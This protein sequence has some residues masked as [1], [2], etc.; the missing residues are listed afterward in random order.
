[1]S[2]TSTS[3]DLGVPREAD[4]LYHQTLNDP[5]DPGCVNACFFQLHIIESS[6]LSWA[7]HVVGTK[8]D[9]PVV[10]IVNVAKAWRRPYLAELGAMTGESLC[11]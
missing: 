4:R 10:P 5:L 1:V 2:E 9:V 8:P 3:L 6:S 7:G 11:P